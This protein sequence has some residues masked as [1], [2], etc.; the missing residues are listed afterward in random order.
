MLNV[1]SSIG[2]LK[3]IIHFMSSILELSLKLIWGWNLFN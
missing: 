3:K 1:N 2:K